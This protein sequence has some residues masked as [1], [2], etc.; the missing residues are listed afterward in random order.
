V[1]VSELP[2]IEIRL[3]EHERLLRNVASGKTP[4]LPLSAPGATFLADD[5]H[6]AAEA[7]RRR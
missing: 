1:P 4:A 2:P 3:L 6:E 5:L 7:L